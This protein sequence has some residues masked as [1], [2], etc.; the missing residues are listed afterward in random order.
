MD[1]D[2]HTVDDTFPCGG[3]LTSCLRGG[4]FLSAEV[5]PPLSALYAVRQTANISLPVNLVIY[6]VQ[7]RLIAHLLVGVIHLI[8]PDFTRF[9][10]INLAYN[11]METTGL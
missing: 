5:A 7:V 9:Y 4:V 2:N 6:S 10:S 3:A 1:Y 8:C 11:N